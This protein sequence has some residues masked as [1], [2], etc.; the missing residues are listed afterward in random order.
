MST[1][2]DKSLMKQ[3][4][5]E[6]KNWGKWGP[7][8]EIG[9]LNYVKASSIVDI[10]Q[11]VQKGKVFS[12]AIN[13]DENG[14]QTGF[15]GRIN[16]LRTMVATGTDA[17]AGKQDYKRLRYSD[18]I[19]TLPTH[20]V[21]HWDALGHLFYEEQDEE[22][23][24]NTV[25]W[26]GYP[27]TFVGAS[28]CEKCGIEKMKDKMVGRGVLLDIP[29]YKSVDYLE[30]GYAITIEDLEGCRK[31]DNVEI[32]EGDF[33]LVRTGQ[34]GRVLKEGKWGTY[35]GGDAPGLDFET[36]KWL[37]EKKVATVATDTWG[38]EVRPN[39]SDEFMQPWHWI[40]IPII[41]LTH[42]EMF[43]LEELAEDC[44]D[45]SVFEFLLVAPVMPLTRG[46]GSPV[47]PI[48]IK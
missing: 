29:R 44:A 18:D 14:P 28:G 37:H 22:G 42:G 7:D 3:Y 40:V 25:M 33:L 27:S 32:R 1:K 5:S 12:L 26:N 30:D 43:Y 31:K 17:A 34:L 47:N 19:I 46:A 45:D 20:G 24:R 15:L 35:A 38:C 39:N 10:A 6:L 9:T 23:N 13:F 2:V 36:L 41:G 4:A 8:D 21:T 16:P 11:K 48:A